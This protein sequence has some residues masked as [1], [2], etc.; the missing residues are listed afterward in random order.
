MP[1]FMT[2]MPAKHEVSDVDP[3]LDAVVI[4]IDDAS[5]RAID[6]T[7]INEPIDL[8]GEVK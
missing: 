7:R 6:I 4:D 1:R 2:C 8:K 3:R 5:G